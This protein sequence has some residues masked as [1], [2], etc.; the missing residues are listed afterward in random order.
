VQPSVVSY[1]LAVAAAAVG[2]MSAL[3]SRHKQLHP[4]HCA[5][6][7]AL[8]RLVCC[9]MSQGSG[10]DAASTSLDCAMC[11][12]Q[13]ELTLK[14]WVQGGQPRMAVREVCPGCRGSGR[15]EMRLCAR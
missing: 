15:S 3:R 7:F 10:F 1:H 8:C 13:G 2:A 9:T 12:G 6:H 4:L 5:S 14:K 11:H